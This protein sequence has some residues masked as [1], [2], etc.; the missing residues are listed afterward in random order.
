MPCNTHDIS[1]S[2]AVCGIPKGGSM[3][4]REEIALDPI[5]P[6]LNMN[7]L[8]E[9]MQP[10][11]GGRPVSRESIYRRINKGLPTHRDRFTGRPLFRL[12]EVAAWWTVPATK[13]S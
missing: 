3:V 8:R 10:I 13:V 1:H 4:V 5:E 2:D 12:S 6:L 9:A 11:L 7:Q